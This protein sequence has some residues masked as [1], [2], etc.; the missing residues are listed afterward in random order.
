MTQHDDDDNE[1]KSRRDFL[2]ASAAV[3]TEKEAGG[4]RAQAPAARGTT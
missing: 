2:K 4:P 3:A 1:K